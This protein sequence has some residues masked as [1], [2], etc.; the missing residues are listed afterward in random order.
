MQH[1]VSVVRFLACGVLD[2]KD[3][4]ERKRKRER[5]RERKPV[6]VII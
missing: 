6:T 5:E 2:D 3:K 1:P 4:R